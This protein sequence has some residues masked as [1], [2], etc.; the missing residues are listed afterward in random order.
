MLI[1]MA[2]AFAYFGW[3]TKAGLA[4]AVGV[5]MIILAQEVPDHGLLIVGGGLALF[6]ILALL[7]LYSYS[8]AA[9]TK[10][11]TAS[12]TTC[13]SSPSLRRQPEVKERGPNR[14]RRQRRKPPATLRAV[15]AF[16]QGRPADDWPWINGPS[17]VYSDVLRLVMNKLQ[18]KHELAVA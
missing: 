18:L 16:R 5:S 11:A 14:L 15:D 9:W 17:V 13:K 3:W 8:R 7:V 6:T 1:I 12:P 4:V 2:G 10:T